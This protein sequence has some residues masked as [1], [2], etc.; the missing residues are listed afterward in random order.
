MLNGHW[1]ICLPVVYR[2]FRFYALCH[3]KVYKSGRQ[4][5]VRPHRRQVDFPS[6]LFCHSKNSLRRE[7]HRCLF[8]ERAGKDFRRD[9]L[10]GEFGPNEADFVGT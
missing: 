4:I 6:R 1:V 5:T 3:P 10:N 2:D 9:K 8:C 7:D